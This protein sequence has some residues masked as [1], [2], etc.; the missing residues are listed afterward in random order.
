MNEIFVDVLK[1][2]ENWWMMCWLRD[3]RAQ[4]NAISK[5]N[6]KSMWR[7]DDRQRR[8]IIKKSQTHSGTKAY[9]PAF[10]EFLGWWQSNWI[11]AIPANAQSSNLYVSHSFNLC[12]FSVAFH[13]INV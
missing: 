8:R 3:F 7:T 11:E 6:T 10:Y 12:G 4:K 13:S 5:A 9:V 2:Q 1:C